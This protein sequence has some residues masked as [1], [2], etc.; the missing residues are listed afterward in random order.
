LAKNDPF[1]IQARAALKRLVA[2]GAI[3]QAEA[4]AVEREV[5][6]GSVDAGA[7]VRDGKVASAHMPAII[8]AITEVKRASEPAGD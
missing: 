5:I 4:E 2:N 8:E 6:A 1:V 3:E 7:L